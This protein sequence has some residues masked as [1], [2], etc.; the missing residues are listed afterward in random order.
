MIKKV[1]NHVDKA[2]SGLIK[3]SSDLEEL[4][5]KYRSTNKCCMDIVLFVIL[6]VMCMVNWK[7][8]QWKGWIP[9]IKIK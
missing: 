7:I 5:G 9:N 1:N 4:L 2:R 3:Q 6:I 8:L